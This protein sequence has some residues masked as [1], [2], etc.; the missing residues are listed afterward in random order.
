MLSF[1]HKQREKLRH[2]VMAH[3]V[4]DRLSHLGIGIAP[5]IIYR[6][7]FSSTDES[8]PF[9]PNVELVT[10]EN[11]EH[12]ISG[13][14]TER[15][16]SPDG[17]RRY[18]KEGHI[19]LVMRLRDDSVG[20]TWAALRDYAPYNRRTELGPKQAYLTSTYI[21]KKFRRQG[22]A[23]LMRQAMY[24]ELRRHGRTEFYS[25]SDFLNTPAKHWKRRMNATPL[26]L[27]LALHLSHRWHADVRLWSYV[28]AARSGILPRNA[29]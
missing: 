13:F 8:S 25:V 28:E 2:G 23:T 16:V 5:Y 19:A 14:A 22:M 1:L 26:E 4:S 21:A 12:L 10:L 6:E 15:Q 29:D 20:Y 24:R 27:R 17:W 9:E 11:C 18:L 7:N 3:S